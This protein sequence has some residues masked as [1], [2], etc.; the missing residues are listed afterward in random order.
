MTSPQQASWLGRLVR[1]GKLTEAAAFALNKL[2]SIKNLPLPASV[3]LVPRE[4]SGKFV[5]AYQGRW[6]GEGAIRL[7]RSIVARA[8]QRERLQNQFEKQV[9]GLAKS[10]ARGDIKVA[11]W[12]QRMADA[13]SN[14]SLRQ[15]A[16]GRGATMSK[17]EAIRF[18]NE[19]IRPQLA[20]L[21][22]FADEI[23]LGK[24]TGEPLTAAQIASRAALYAGDG[25]AAW[26]Q[27]HERRDARPGYVAKYRARDGGGT[28]SNCLAAVGTYL[29][30]EGVQPGEACKGKGRCRCTRELVLDPAAYQRLTG[31]VI[32]QAN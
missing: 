16:L 17:A 15:A 9:A 28:C 3:G 6:A 20:F 4:L 32:S 23:A 18:S 25:R 22:R 12:Q 10:V 19:R 31:T 7:N 14:H 1:V 2:G 24:A 29:P 11:V 26:F 30:G 27:E 8:A 21:Q 5:Q 13:I